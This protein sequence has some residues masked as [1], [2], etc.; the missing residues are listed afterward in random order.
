MVAT[1]ALRP[2]EDA[3]PMVG[4][5]SLPR[6]MSCSCRAAG[7]QRICLDEHRVKLDP[8]QPDA[9]QERLVRLIR[10]VEP[11]VVL[12]QRARWVV[13]GF[14]PNVGESHYDSCV[15]ARR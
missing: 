12:T 6:E 1:L 4:G 9:M 5:L 13:R 11:Q 7:I 3:L 14:R 2:R 10:Q 8:S 15:W